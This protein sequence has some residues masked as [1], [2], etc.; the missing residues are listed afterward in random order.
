MRV[1]LCVH[2]SCLHHPAPLTCRLPPPPAGFHRAFARWAKPFNP[3]LGETWQAEMPDGSR[4]FL[5]QIS[6]HPPISAF[7]LLGP[8]G[9][10]T[11]AGQRQAHFAWQLP[12]EHAIAAAGLGGRLQIASA[13]KPVTPALPRRWSAAPPPATTPCSQPSVSYKT[14]AV[15]TT[16]RGYRVVDF[17]DGGRVEIHYPSYYLKGAHRQAAA[18]TGG[19]GGDWGI[20]SMLWQGV[21]WLNLPASLPVVPTHAA[22]QFLPALPH[23]APVHRGA[24]GGGGRHR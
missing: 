4:I 14:N 19:G 17:A 2:L 6:H 11:F 12:A 5:E 1:C 8:H 23:R 20:G 10:Y 18:V 7:E 3:L 9:L 15:K 13:C 16:A 22:T 21:G 24:A